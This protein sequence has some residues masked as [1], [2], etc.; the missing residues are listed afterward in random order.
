MI[1][2]PIAIFFHLTVRHPI[3]TQKKEAQ[4]KSCSEKVEKNTFGGV[5]L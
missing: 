2:D 1:Y 4:Q 3:H 5:L